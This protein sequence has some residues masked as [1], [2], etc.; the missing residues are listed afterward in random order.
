MLVQRISYGALLIVGVVAIV[1]G[2]LHIA[3]GATVAEGSVSLQCGSLIPLAVLLLALFGTFEMLNLTRAANFEPMGWIIIV[4][5]VLLNAVAWLLPAV[6]PDSGARVLEYQLV[7][8]VLAAMLC[9]VA[10]V[11]RRRAER[12]IGDIS[13]SI[14]MLV[15][16][17]VLPSFITT[18]RVSLPG[19]L[20]VWAVIL[21][22]A[23]VK[24]TDIGAYFTGVAVGKTKLIP[25]ISPGKTVEGLAGGVLLA[26]VASCLLSRFLPWPVDPGGRLINAY[27]AVIFGVVVGVIGQFGDLVESVIKRDAALKDSA[28]V[29]P[30][31]GGILDLLDSPVF[32]AP[33][34]Y[35]LLSAW[36]V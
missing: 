3:D 36:L 10:Q 12:G 7:I 9:A 28:Q 32:A 5:V 6:Y 34:G 14:F 13:V 19:S 24:C 8:L 29:I 22:V 31:F 20:G 23:T 2:D 11:L 27:Q 25:T 21:F 15:Y 18:L 26:V 1:F 4:G 33:I 30:A 16:M 35:L 17:G